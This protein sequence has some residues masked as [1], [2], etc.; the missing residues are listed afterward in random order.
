MTLKEI[1]VKW[2]K[3]KTIW[4]GHLLA[5]VGILEANIGLLRDNLGEYYGYAFIAIAL[6]T[7]FLRSKTNK[8]LTD[9]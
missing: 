4:F 5:L 9:K 7:Y 3:S 2:H 1:T 6:M 8:A